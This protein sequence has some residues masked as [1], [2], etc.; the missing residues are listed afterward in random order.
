MDCLKPISILISNRVNTDRPDP[1]KQKVFEVLRT[2][3]RG[4]PEITFSKLEK[5][6]P[7][8]QSWYEK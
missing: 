4:S 3:R 7:T 8:S 6:P 5:T 2:Y 1:Q